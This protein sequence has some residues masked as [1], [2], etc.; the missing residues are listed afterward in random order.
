[1]VPWALE[2]DSQG[3]FAYVVNSE[4]ATV[5]QYSVGANG[6]LEALATPPVATGVGPW[7]ITL[8]PNGKYAYVSNYGVT[9][10]NFPCV[11]ST[12]G[13]YAIAPDTGALS[14]LNPATGRIR[15]LPRR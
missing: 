13:Q 6:V 14:P 15:D 2:F 5:S 3:K 4:D 10:G 12:V 1:M 7:N 9:P 11:G 8:S